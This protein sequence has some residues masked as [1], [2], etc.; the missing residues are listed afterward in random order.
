MGKNVNLES[1]TTLSMKSTASLRNLRSAVESLPPIIDV[2]A[3]N[4]SRSGESVAV[5]NPGSAKVRDTQLKFYF[6]I[7]N[8]YICTIHKLTLSFVGFRHDRLHCPKKPA[9]N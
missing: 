8:V 3:G 7:L 4:Y 2:E 9:K 5:S 6:Y 1:E